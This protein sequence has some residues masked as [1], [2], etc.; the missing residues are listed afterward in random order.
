M[1]GTY[2]PYK[3]AEFSIWLGNFI[4]VAS[5]NAIELGLTTAE[6]NVIKDMQISYT[7]YLADVEA[8]KAEL[9]GAVE[10]K[11]ATKSNIIIDV[12][13]LVNKIQAKPDVPTALKAQ[14]GISTRDGGTQPAHPIAVTDLVAKLTPDGSIELSWNRNGNSP[15]TNFMIEYIDE[16]VND[17]KLLDVVSKTTYLHKGH[18]L[19]IPIKYIVKARR[20]D[21]ISSASNIAYIQ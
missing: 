4:S 19:S 7:T 1:A 6:I 17:W 8:K 14:L 20:V 3:D 16:T 12:R 15:T 18:P 9:A 11:D 5:V 13:L 21:E 10:T 2:Y